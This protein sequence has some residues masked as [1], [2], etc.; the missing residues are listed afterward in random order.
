MD[1]MKN[2]IIKTHALLCLLSKMVLVP[3]KC[4]S[5]KWQAKDERAQHY[6]NRADLAAKI[7]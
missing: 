1:I 2:S 5:L 3:N 4:S 6:K 7:K